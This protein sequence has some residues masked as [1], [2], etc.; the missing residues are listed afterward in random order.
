MIVFI[1]LLMRDLFR[2]PITYYVCMPH[3]VIRGRAPIALASSLCPI[4]NLISGSGR[5]ILMRVSCLH[6]RFSGVTKALLR[7]NR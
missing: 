4:S 6:M 5:M 7:L 1:V 2:D 3:L